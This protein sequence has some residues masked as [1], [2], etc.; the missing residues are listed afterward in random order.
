MVFAIDLDDD[1]GSIRDVRE[2]TT[3]HVP[4]VETLSVDTLPFR[5]CHRV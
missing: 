4:E 1:P 2:G 5:N 3:L